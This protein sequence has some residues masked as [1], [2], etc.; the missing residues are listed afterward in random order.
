MTDLIYFSSFFSFLPSFLNLTTIAQLAKKYK[1]FKL[2]KYKNEYEKNL[3]YSNLYSCDEEIHMR[4]AEM[5][6]EIW[7]SK[8]FKHDLGRHLLTGYHWSSFFPMMENSHA[9]S[10][11]SV[12]SRQSCDK[13]PPLHLWVCHSCSLDKAW[14]S[15]SP[16]ASI[17]NSRLT[18]SV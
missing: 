6:L 2:K 12:I 4:A 8:I 17:M 9:H 18:V 1:T 13:Y 10:T 3:F 15:L 5:Q 14:T 11:C 7:L 16:T